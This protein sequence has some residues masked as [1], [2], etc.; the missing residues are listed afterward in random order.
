MHDF[1]IKKKIKFMF[2][3]YNFCVNIRVGIFVIFF[4]TKLK[5]QS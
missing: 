3:T 1:Y 5:F 4:N 2:G